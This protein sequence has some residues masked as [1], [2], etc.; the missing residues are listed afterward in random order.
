MPKITITF[1]EDGQQ[2]SVIEIPE[3][4]AAVLDRHV[5]YLRAEGQ[6]VAGKTDLFIRFTWQNWLKPVLERQ[7]LSVRQLAG[8]AGQQAAELEARLAQA[9]AA[10]EMAAVRAVVRRIEEVK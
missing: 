7:G 3:P 10:E 6:P 8:P 9:R 2:P 1:Q 5:A 4:I